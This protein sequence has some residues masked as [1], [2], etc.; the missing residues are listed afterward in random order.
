MS[1][2]IISELAISL[3]FTVDDFGTVNATNDQ[4]KIWADR[5]RAVIGTALGERIYRPE[6][7]CEAALTTFDNEEILINGIADNIRASFDAFLPL[8][9]L[10]NVE[11]SVEESSRI[12]FV[13]VVYST[14][15]G[16]EYL[17]KVGIATIDGLNPISEELT[18][19][20]Q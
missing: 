3:P 13:E 20:T 9:S 16:A 18:W 8:L 19:Q 4:Q 10:E 11:V 12:I 5:V 2:S 1:L 7:G 17:I 15:N 6:F 14:S